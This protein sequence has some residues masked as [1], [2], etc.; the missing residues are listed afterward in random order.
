MFYG[1]SFIFDDVP[2]E[3]YNLR[4]LDFEQTGGVNDSPAGSESTIHQTWLYRKSKPYF[5]GTS[6]NIPL[7][8]NFTVGSFNSI[9]ALDRGTIDKWLLGRSTYLPLQICQTDMQD[10][11]FNVIF[12]ANNKYVGNLQ[13]GIMLNATCDAPWGFEKEKTL[14]YSFS[15]GATQNLNF[16]FYNNSDDSGYLYPSII[17][18]TND[19]GNSC[20]LTNHTDSERKFEFTGILADETITIDNYLQIL[21]TD[22]GLKRMS[23]FNKYFFR[24]LPGKNELTLQGG[25]LSFAMTYQFA[26]KIGG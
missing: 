16:N 5:Y 1:S 13:K 18:K 25:L 20:T 6:L 2:S 23:T 9:H 22:S 21:T 11:Y 7:T 10:I 12:S 3:N 4:I 24:L 26:R 15:N 8:F 19:I 17:F 14:T